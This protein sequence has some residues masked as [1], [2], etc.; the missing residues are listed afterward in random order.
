MFGN[1][2]EYVLRAILE[3]E[4]SVLRKLVSDKAF[5]LHEPMRELDGTNG[6]YFI[7]NIKDILKIEIFGREFSIPI[8]DH[9]VFVYP[10]DEERGG[11]KL[12]I[13]RRRDKDELPKRPHREN[14]E[15][16]FSSRPQE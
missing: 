16:S 14:D 15:P 4:N 7:G 9:V 6:Y 13:K 2:A 3:N 11:A 1:L 10:N 5:E 8:L 12:V